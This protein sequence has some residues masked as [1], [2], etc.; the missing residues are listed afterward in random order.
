MAFLRTLNGDFKD[1]RTIL[2]TTNR[3]IPVAGMSIRITSE[4]RNMLCLRREESD[5]KEKMVNFSNV[6]N[7][8]LLGLKMSVAFR[9]NTGDISKSC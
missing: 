2:Q 1:R 4:N 6:A 7:Q 8:V 3:Q 5:K 9:K